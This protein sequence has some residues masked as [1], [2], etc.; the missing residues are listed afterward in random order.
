MRHT[1]NEVIER[2]IYE[3]E[4]LDRLVAS[5]TEVEWRRQVQ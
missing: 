2:T 4:L 3:F 1:R 5:L